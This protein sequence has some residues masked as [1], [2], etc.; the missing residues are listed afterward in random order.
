MELLNQKLIFLTGTLKN[1]L[2]NDL[3]LLTVCINVFT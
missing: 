2:L 3:N 1:I